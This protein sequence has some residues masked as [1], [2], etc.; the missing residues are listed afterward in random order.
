M[1]GDKT[2]SVVTLISK[3]LRW[4]KPFVARLKCNSLKSK[5]TNVPG[6]GKARY[7]LVDKEN[8]LELDEAVNHY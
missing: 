8:L 4:P 2:E 3:Q 6:L 1:F 7:Y 5:T